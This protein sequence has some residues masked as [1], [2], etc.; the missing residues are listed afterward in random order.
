MDEPDYIVLRGHPAYEG[1]WV[2]AA[3]VPHEYEGKPT[4]PFDPDVVSWLSFR[5]TD[6]FEFRDDGKVAQVWKVEVQDA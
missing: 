4:I 1:I 2:D 6:E 3:Q 5:S